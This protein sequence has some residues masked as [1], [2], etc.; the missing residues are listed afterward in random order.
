VLIKPLVNWIWIGCILLSLGTVI[1]LWPSVDLRRTAEM[2]TVEPADP[3]LAGA[4]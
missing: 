1:A 4:D 3:A 2:A